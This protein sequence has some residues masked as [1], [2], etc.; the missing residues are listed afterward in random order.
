MKKGTL[1]LL[2]PLFMLLI[3]SAALTGGNS[4]ARGAVTADA[5]ENLAQQG[6]KACVPR[7]S[8]GE[9][10]SRARRCDAR[11]AHGSAGPKLV[12]ASFTECAGDLPRGLAARRAR[13]A[14]N[15]AIV[16]IVPSIAAA[17]A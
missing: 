12:V 13:P 17:G 11:A 2:A 16:R 3:V 14:I 10:E 7:S 5:A 6:I 4:P 1:L 9:E 8:T 15:A